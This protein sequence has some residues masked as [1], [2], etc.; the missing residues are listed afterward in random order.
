MERFC[1]T[2]EAMKY[3]RFPEGTSIFGNRRTVERTLRRVMKEKREDY[4]PI[5]TGHQGEPGSI[6]TRIADKDTPYKVE[7]GDKVMISAHLIPNDMNR[8]QRYRMFTLLKAQGARVFDD[9]HVS[10]H[11]YCEDHYEM[12]QLLQPTYVIAAHGGLDIT[13]D[14]VNMARDFGYM[15]NKDFF[16][17]ANG[18]KQRLM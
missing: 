3:V 16:L 2:A 14:Y 6:L 12:L 9:I 1:A 17:M 4:V 10:G 5:V 18:Q 15:L 13:S 7:K 11:A 8:A